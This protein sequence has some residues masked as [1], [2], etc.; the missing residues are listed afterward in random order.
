MNSMHAVVV[1]ELMARAEQALRAAQ[2]RRDGAGV[3]RAR[4]WLAQLELEAGKLLSQGSA[5]SS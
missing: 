3:A 2:E 5:S 1:A 4:S